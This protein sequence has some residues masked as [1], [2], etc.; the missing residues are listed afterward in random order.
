MGLARMGQKQLAE[1]TNQVSFQRIWFKK[2]LVW[3][4]IC[5]I[6]SSY[7]LHPKSDDSQQNA[8]VRP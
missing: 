2:N 8:L 4:Y 1:Y 5:V 7:F 3:I 6:R